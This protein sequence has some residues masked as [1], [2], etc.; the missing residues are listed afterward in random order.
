M[1]DNL[2][3]KVFRTGA[4]SPVSPPAGDPVK[5]VLSCADIIILSILILTMSCRSG[6]KTGIKFDDDPALVKEA[7][8]KLIPFGTTIEKAEGIMTENNFT[9]RLMKKS[10]FHDN[11]KIYHNIDFLYCDRSRGLIV[12]RRWQ[13]AIVYTNEKVDDVY[14]SS[15]LTGP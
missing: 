2:F 13:V 4:L 7:I 12:S 14:V 15:G 8:K 11:E 5:P 3:K 6:I 9:C 10:S 1:Y